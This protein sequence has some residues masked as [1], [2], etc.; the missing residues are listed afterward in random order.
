[1]GGKNYYSSY[2]KFLFS[3]L[4][5][6]QP[7]NGRNLIFLSFSWIP[8]RALVTIKILFGRLQLLFA[9]QTG[10]TEKQFPTVSRT[11]F[12]S[13]QTQSRVWRRTILEKSKN[14]TTATHT[15]SKTNKQPSPLS[16]FST[17]RVP[18]IIIPKDKPTLSL[19]SF[20]SFFFFFSWKK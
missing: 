8:N 15:R 19:S 14:G 11:P 3:S 13:C 1:M 16:S 7:N 20:S 10:T 9:V 4:F 12:A 6:L 17:P 18:I 5:L 2:L